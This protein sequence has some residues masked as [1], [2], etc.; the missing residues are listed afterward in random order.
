ME[1]S[2]MDERTKMLHARAKKGDADA[3]DLL[4]A[5]SADQVLLFIGARLGAGLRRKEDPMD[6]LQ[7][8]WMEAHRSFGEF[9]YRG[10]GC[11][12]AWLCRIAENRIRGLADHHGARKRSAPGEQLPVSRVLDRIRAAVTGP[13]TAALRQ[14]QQS[15]LADALAVLPDE[16]REV[17]LHRH[18]LDRSYDEIAEVLNRPATTVRRQ[19]GRATKRLGEALASAG[20]AR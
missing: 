11:F 14:E 9:V 2:N 3:L 1:P 12:V 20:G 8:T 7:E 5:G 16:E 19:V 6:V 15:R 13:A 4:F 17:L 18:F 10:K